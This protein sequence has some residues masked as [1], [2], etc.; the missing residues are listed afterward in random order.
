MSFIMMIRPL[1]LVLL[2]FSGQLIFLEKAVNEY[3][4][5]ASIKELFA[6]AKFGVHFHSPFAD[7]IGEYLQKLHDLEGFERFLEF[8]RIL[9]LM[10]RSK[11]Y[12][13]LASPNYSKTTLNYSD[14]RLDRI[15]NFINLNYTEKITLTR[16]SR[17]LW[18]EPFGHEP[19]F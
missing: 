14:Q 6:R 13:L 19:L 15:I 4:E 16:F 7:K 3:P 17:A 2:L 10:S 12:R 1:E 9:E 8:I 18:Y 5:M 11:E